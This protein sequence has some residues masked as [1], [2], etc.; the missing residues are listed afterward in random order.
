MKKPAIFGCFLA[1]A[2]LAAA[3]QAPAADA[4]RRSPPAYSVAPLPI[5]PDSLS[6]A[7]LASDGCWRSCEAWC[8]F[9]LRKCTKV[10]DLTDCLPQSDACDRGC[11]RQCRVYG[12]PFL[13]WTD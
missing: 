10:F 1:L 6:A 2:T 7:V 13:N 4:W 11:L 5:A 9:R 8:G 3:A 12:G